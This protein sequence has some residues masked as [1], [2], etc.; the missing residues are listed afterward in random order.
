MNLKVG[1]TGQREE[2]EGVA[3]VC[4]DPAAADGA[5]VGVGA[6][7]GAAAGIA[8]AG[9]GDLMPRP[10]Q[11]LS[12]SRDPAPLQEPCHYCFLLRPPL[13]AFAVAAAVAASSA[14]A[15][16]TTSHT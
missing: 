13:L 1:E 3:E 2:V 11:P 16:G 7:A 4:K 10:P 5:A 12:G 6:A 9:A 14:A 8:C 15:A